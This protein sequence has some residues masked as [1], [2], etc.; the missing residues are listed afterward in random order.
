MLAWITVQERKKEQSYSDYFSID[1][2][3]SILKREDE[4]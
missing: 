2:F 3:R 4:K 1:N